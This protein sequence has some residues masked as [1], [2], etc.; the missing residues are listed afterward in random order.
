M[1]IHSI[2]LYRYRQFVSLDEMS[3]LF[4]KF[5][6]TMAKIGFFRSS[7]SKKKILSVLVC[8]GLRLIKELCLLPDQP[9][10]N[11]A[12]CAA[13][14]KLRLVNYIETCILVTDFIDY[15]ILL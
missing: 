5:N 9:M 11:Q 2:Y 14:T 7:R 3:K 10:T 1:N 8:V 4:R 15:Y 13:H 12:L 6:F